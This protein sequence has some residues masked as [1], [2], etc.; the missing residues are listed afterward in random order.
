MALST[1]EFTEE[2]VTISFK[3]LMDELIR[4]SAFTVLSDQAVQDRMANGDPVPDPTEEDFINKMMAH[5]D[6]SLQQI[7]DLAA[8]RPMLFEMVY[9]R[10]V[11]NFLLYISDILT[12][13]HKVKPEILKSQEKVDLEFI[14]EHSSMDELIA[15]LIEKRVV[16][17]AMSS[18]RELNKYVSN[19]LGIE[20]FDTEDHFKIG[21]LL[22]EKRN[23]IIHNRGIMNRVFHERVSVLDLDINTTIGGKIKIRPDDMITALRLVG[24]FCLALDRKV[25]TKF[26]GLALTTIRVTGKQR[27]IL[28]D[29]NSAGEND[30]R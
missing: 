27:D 18:M 28:S 22:I 15:S 9:C 13:V 16:S 8:M 17:L 4:L 11:D 24:V 1:G 2:E 29:S 25:R 21:V 20:L 5:L 30:G 23:L 14:M 12:E 3:N 10:A 19:R 7:R 6:A 26:S